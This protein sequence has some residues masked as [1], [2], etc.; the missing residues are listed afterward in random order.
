MSYLTAALSSRAGSNMVRATLP[1]TMSTMAMCAQPPLCGAL[2]HWVQPILFILGS[3]HSL[4]STAGVDDVLSLTSVLWPGLSL[5]HL[6]RPS[7]H[8]LDGFLPLFIPTLNSKNLSKWLLSTFPSEIRAHVCRVFYNLWTFL[9]F[10]LE[11]WYKLI[12][13]WGVKSHKHCNRRQNYHWA[14]LKA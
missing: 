1:H 13:R 8:L 14:V 2:D 11:L 12:K 4:K 10:A 6:G 7:Q 3:R 9:L 5:L